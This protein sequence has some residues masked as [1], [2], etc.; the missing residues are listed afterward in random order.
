M[1]KEW[2]CRK[3]GEF[4]ASHPICPALGCESEHVE[5]VFLTAPKIKSDR[6]RVTDQTL[7]ATA[8]QT[9]FDFKKPGDGS[10]VLWGEEA[11]KPY[12]GVAGM[13][14][15]SESSE[16]LTHSPNAMRLIGGDEAFKT[17]APRAQRIY[18][19]DDKRGA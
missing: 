3:H 12:G 2:K 11:A 18:S 8:N 7:Q 15:A 14:A 17:V 10:Q 1:L 16:R 13:M 19:A 5:R 9:G 4:E 6:T